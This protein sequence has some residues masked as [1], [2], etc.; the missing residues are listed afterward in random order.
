M[1]YRFV[2]GVNGALQCVAFVSFWRGVSSLL[3][4][5]TG[6]VGTWQF[7][8]VVVFCGREGRVYADGQEQGA[9]HMA[10]EDEK[11]RVM[12]EI[13]YVIPWKQR[14]R[15][16]SWWRKFRC[17]V[18]N[19]IYISGFMVGNFYFLPLFSLLRSG[20]NRKRR[21]EFSPNLAEHVRYSFLCG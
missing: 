14:G 4:C 3:F 5:A 6:G 15:V 7:L 2:S 9:R 1:A 20:R 11:P 21:R 12:T 16:C 18:S 17:N 13:G 8:G 10:G 19:F